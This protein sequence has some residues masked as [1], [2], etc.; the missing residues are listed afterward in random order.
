[1]KSYIGIMLLCTLMVYRVSFSQESQVE[2]QEF[3]SSF[4]DNNQTI[5]KIKLNT[6]C[7]FSLLYS[8]YVKYHEPIDENLTSIFKNILDTYRQTGRLD[9]TYRLAPIE[10]TTTNHRHHTSNEVNFVYKPTGQ[11]SSKGK[12]LG[13]EGDN[14]K[15]NSCINADVENGDFDNWVMAYSTLNGLA[16]LA[17]G[18]DNPGM[19]SLLGNHVIMGP[20]S[21]T[22]A[23]TGGNVPR[24]YPGGGT[25]SLRL[26]DEGTGW[27]AAKATYTFVVTPATELFIY[28]YAVVLEDP[29]HM[30]SL[31]PYLEIKLTIDG[32]DE[33]CGYYY[34]A[35]AG[36]APGFEYYQTGGQFSTTI[37]YKNWSTNSIVMTPYMGQT[38][39]VEFITED[40]AE[41]GH[42]GYAYID[43]E[44]NEM[45]TLT[46]ASLTC[47]ESEITLT[48]PPGATGYA[49]TGPGIVG[50]T[51]QM[52]AVVDTPGTYQ[53][54]VIPS[55][56]ASC[57]YVIDVE[58]TDDTGGVVADFDVIS[59]P[60]CVGASILFDN[61]STTTTGPGPFSS[62]VWDFGDGETSTEDSPTHSYSA[63]GTY[64]VSLTVAEAN[65]C[66]GTTTQEVN[67]TSGPD[68]DFSFTE[69][70]EGSSTVFEDLSSVATASNDAIS[71]CTWDF[72]DGNTATTQNPSHQYGSEG[73]YDVTLIAETVNGC[74]GEV[75]LPVVVN[76]L[77]VSSFVASQSCV[78]EE[79]DFTDQSTVSSGNTIESWAWDFTDGNNASTQNPTHTYTTSGTYNPTLTV[80]SN[81]GCSATVSNEVLVYSAPVAGFTATEAC[82]NTAVSFTGEAT[83]PGGMAG[84]VVTGWNWD[85]GDGNTAS[86][87]NPSHSYTNSGTYT[88]TL[89]VTTNHGCTNTF[90]QDITIAP[91]PT[92]D[93]TVA[94][95][96]EGETFTFENESSADP[97]FNDPIVDWSWD[98][99]DGNTSIDENTS[100]PYS[101]EGVYNV[102][103]TVESANGCVNSLTLP[104][105]VYANPTASFVSA[106]SCLGGETVFTDESVVNNTTTTSN[107]TNWDWDFGDGNTS[108]EQ[109]PSNTYNV[110]GTFNPTLTV[111]TDNGCSASVSGEV[112]IN[113]GPSFDIVTNDACLNTVMTFTDEIT[114]NQGSND[115]ITT[116]SWDFGDG[117]TSNQEHPNHTYTD[118]GTYTVSVEVSTGNGCVGTVNED[119][120]VFPL[121]NASFG[122][123][124]SC[125]G[126]LFT[127]SDES[128]TDVTYGDPINS[129]LWNFDD[130]NTSANQNPT[131]AFDDEGVYG[132][133]L[134]VETVN[135]CVNEVTLPAEV[136]PSPTASFTNSNVCFGEGTVFTNESFSG[137]TSSTSNIV[138]WEWDFTD[139]NTSTEENPTHTFANEGTYYPTLTVTSDNGCTGTVTG[140]VEVYALP[141]ANFNAEMAC[142]STPTIF[143]DASVVGGAGSN[144]T[145][146]NWDWDFGD[147]NASTV[148]NPENTYVNGENFDVSLTVTSNFGCVDSYTD[149]VAVFINPTADFITDSV[150]LGTTNS[151]QDVSVADQTN[152]DSVDDW[153]WDFGDNATDTIKNPTHTYDSEGSYQVVLTV[154]S[155]K[156]CSAAITKSVLVYPAPVIDVLISKECLNT[157][158][159]FTDQSTVNSGQT[160][161]QIDGWNWD[162]GDGNTSVDQ[163]PSYTFDEEGIYDVSLTVST[164]KGCSATSILEV[165]VFPNPVVDFEVTDL[166]LGSAASFNDLST[167]SNLQTSNTINEW[168]W[169][170]GDGNTETVQNPSHTY[171]S[172]G[173]YDVALTVTTDNGCSATD[174]NEVT[175]F[176]KPV[177]VVSLDSLCEGTASS[178]QDGSTLDNTNGDVIN[179]W[180]WN[181]GDGQ[182]SN[183]QTPTYTYPNEG[184]YNVTL[185][186]TTNNGC[187][188]TATA[189]TEIYPLPE[190]SFTA[191]GVC[192][193][194]LS[195]FLDESTISNAHT[196]NQ[197]EAWSWDFGDNE[198]SA[199]A[200]PTHSYSA[201]GMYQVTLTVTSNHGCVSSV[202][203]PVHV[204][205]IPNI[206]FTGVDLEGC[207]PICPE[208]TATTGVA[209]SE[210]NVFVWTLS[211]GTVYEGNSPVL[212]DCF[213]N[214]SGENISYGLHLSVTTEH[215][216]VGEYGEENYIT[217]FSNPTANF[218]LSPNQLDVIDP[219]V[220]ISNSSQNA[221]GYFWD[222]EGYGTSNQSVPSNVVLPAQAGSYGITLIAY[223]ENGC[224][225]TLEKTIDVMDELIFYV[226]N[227]FTPDQN[228]YN[229]LFSPVFANGVDSQDYTLYIFNRWGE[230]VFE[231]HNPEVG[232]DGTYGNQTY[233]KAKEG[234]YVWKLRFKET[235]TDKHHSFVGHVN[236]L[237]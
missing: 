125:Q 172:D 129:W 10:V 103:L 169:D 82:L 109:N 127:F 184:V 34:Q 146:T 157:P 145:I 44:C 106:S 139:G 126:G 124:P 149:E 13:N 203:A 43:A 85:L 25:Y 185:T 41:Q 199:L 179:N 76:P 87:Q 31:Q 234:T 222:I 74:T 171:A 36:N 150:C 159:V 93:F 68:V 49:W 144:S 24:V 50:A 75:T 181:F 190:A 48:G 229:E 62:T 38:A 23:M 231:S 17:P 128:T 237:R 220:Y 167:V 162:F 192:E 95:T 116:W 56:G 112:I 183:V 154:T 83:I 205:P 174:I 92:V 113:A 1:M 138:A 110:V 84:E 86:V 187:S 215:G 65:G 77:P 121:P 217:V 155:D 3:I 210:D 115:P 135:G 201:E 120:T 63:P 223:T 198:V 58:V 18:V 180:V 100:N 214:E 8:Q 147:G 7:E 235:Q 70:C 30:P 225:D 204:Y 227:T 178:F 11:S 153:H 39:T 224:T 166:C 9:T 35:A 79:I 221:T 141:V 156:G 176:P 122:H 136:S 96:C 21:G 97:N 134:T 52:E 148:Q 2:R 91:G 213:E 188:D 170:L 193:N 123:I 160:S 53:V 211:D 173:T 61:T 111:T 71:S 69:V 55:S 165:T 182:T 67:V 78:G 202:T 42:F 32:V 89:E 29:G 40:C 99:G 158:T 27:N 168:L 212:Y 45:P 81:N 186:V 191:S 108:T 14:E 189:V 140:E 226:P 143:S 4:F 16:N 207:S 60:A 66:G 15:V 161:N 105:E 46:Q 102:S 132:V 107:I 64:T 33:P 228:Q 233:V 209:P 80:V 164:D 73:T 101:D 216:C 47:S 5:D 26:G 200:N 208:V 28:H 206:G 177:A 218:M 51:D 72:G 194:A 236:L 163:H 230:L 118:P 142:L 152:N 94:G 22:D 90:S 98:F 88:V 20:G 57:A 117:T 12:P 175:V 133:S 131:H 137:G 19:N 119:V 59:Q 130:G 54:A 195:E 151:F 232:W 197:I 114:G 219:T 37:R 6:Q 104:V 196:V